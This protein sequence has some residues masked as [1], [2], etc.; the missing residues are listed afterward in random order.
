MLD[1]ERGRVAN[2]RLPILSYHS[3]DESESVLSVSPALFRQQMTYLHANGWRTLR[4]DQLLAGDA[5][6]AWPARSFVI[7]FD[8]GF[9]NLV[10]HALPALLQCGFGAVVFLVAD[11]VGR[12]NDWPGQPSWVK[13]QV[14]MDWPQARALA[15]AGFDVGSHTLSHPRLTSLAR[16]ECEHEI[17]ASKQVIEDRLGRAVQVFAY[18]YGDANP[19]TEEIV[20]SAYRAGFST[21]LGLVTA[22]SRRSA[23]ERIDMYYLR[24]PRLFGALGKGWL[25]RYLWLRQSIRDA[26]TYDHEATGAL[27]W[28]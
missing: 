16:A 5:R 4:I 19:A 2:R 7:A 28:A 3:I 17:V 12:K 21:R 9:A 15:D 23:F 18:P 10:D 20:R 13:P 25:E 6:G 26:R 8:D 27:T 22:T 24:S 1:D 11:W 14:L